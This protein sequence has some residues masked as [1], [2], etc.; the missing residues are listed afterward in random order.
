MHILHILF[1][2]VPLFLRQ[3]YF[4]QNLDMDS[5]GLGLESRFGQPELLILQRYHID[6]NLNDFFHQSIW[7]IALRGFFQP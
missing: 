5:K 4:Q 2:S 3:Y 7:L 1:E 6:S